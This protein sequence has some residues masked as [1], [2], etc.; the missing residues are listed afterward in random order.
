M[1]RRLR[2]SSPDVGPRLTSDALA[3]LAASPHL[4]R[5]PPAEISR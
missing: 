1:P 4:R 3:A 5:V 2:A